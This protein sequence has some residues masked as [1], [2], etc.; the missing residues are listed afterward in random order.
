MRKVVL[1][2]SIVFYFLISCN[3]S[4]QEVYSEEFVMTYDGQVGTCLGVKSFVDT[5]DIGRLNKVL[6]TGVDYN[7]TEVGLFDLKG[8]YKKN[9]KIKVRVTMF[10]RSGEMICPA[11]LPY[12]VVSVLS[13]QLIK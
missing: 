2:A 13:E 1:L 8:S 7:R 11:F 3:K 10:L 12:P 4:E 9:D 6:G 5:I